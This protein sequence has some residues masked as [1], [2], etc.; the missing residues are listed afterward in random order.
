MKYKRTLGTL[1]VLEDLEGSEGS[2]TSNELVA[3][4]ALVGLLVRVGLV[5]GVVR[6][7]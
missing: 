3:D 2:T 7:V 5:V 6:F 4:L 1:A